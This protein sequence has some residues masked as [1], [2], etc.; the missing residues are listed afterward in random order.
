M[1]TPE[2]RVAE[3]S[4][5]NGSADR[6]IPRRIALQLRL[7]NLCFYSRSYEAREFF[8]HFTQLAADLTEDLP[9]LD[10]FP[11]EVKAALISTQPVREKLPALKTFPQVIRY[12]PAHYRRYSVNLQGSFE[13]Y[14]EKF[15]AKSRKNLARE[16]RKFTEFCGG[17]LDWKEYRAIREAEEF[18]KLA[19][20][21]SGKSWQETSQDVGFP[22]SEEFH[23]EVQDL[24]AHN[25]MR[26]YVLFHHERPVAYAYCDVEDG[27]LVYGYVG[28]DAEYERWSPGTILL[29]LIIQKQFNDH[30]FPMFDLGGREDWYKQFF[31]TQSVLCADILYFRRSA[32]TW[33]FLLLH[34]FLSSFNR[35]V[36]RILEL[37]RLKA[38][39]RKLL[40]RKVPAHAITQNNKELSF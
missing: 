24:A 8:V 10:Q 29:Y 31:S 35:F 39:V 28:Y 34:L 22:S 19:K 25:A 9:S 21:V 40:R 26:G 20:E 2:T 23:R 3:K 17:V 7:G 13:T 36:S 33:L 12:V 16:V 6:W 5:P 32:V 37:L 38:A 18:E 4:D 1:S 27:V 30:A 15:S 11:A 14:L